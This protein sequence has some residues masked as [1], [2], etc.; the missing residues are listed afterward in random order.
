LSSSI[1]YPY[2]KGIGFGV[3]LWIVPVIVIPNIINASRPIIFRTELEC[4]VEL[5]AHVIFVIIA[6]AFLTGNAGIKKPLPV[7]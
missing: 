5:I 7:K 2:D 6:T 4:I 3:L 1:D